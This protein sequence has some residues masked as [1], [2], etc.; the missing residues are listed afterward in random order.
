MRNKSGVIILTILISLLCIYYLSFTFISRGVQKDAEVYATENGVVNKLKRQQ[1]LDSV[2]NEPVYDILGYSY[3][4]KSIKESELNLGL[5]LQGG[6]HVTLEVSPVEII[7]GLSGNS[8]DATFLKAL[9]DA[10]AAVKHTRW[11]QMAGFKF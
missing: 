2:W 4:Y 8:K 5:D 9:E 6:M 11:R 7:K 3:T 1:Y 10:K